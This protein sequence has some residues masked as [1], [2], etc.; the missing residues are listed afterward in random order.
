MKVVLLAGGLGSRLSEETDIRPKPLVQIGNRPILW[1]IMQMYARAGFDEFVVAAGYKGEL[2]ASYFDPGGPGMDM[3][4]GGWSVQVVDTGQATATAGRLRRLA[5]VLD[6]RPFMVTYGDGLADI[7]LNALVA[8]HGSHDVAA[9]ITAVRPP[10]RFGEVRF[11]DDARV[12]FSEKPQV[13]AGWINGGFMVMEPEVLALID[14]DRASLEYDILEPLA[15]QGRVAAY[16]HTSFW[17]CMDT[18]RDVRT[19][20]ELWDSGQAPWASG[21]TA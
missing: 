19:L 1:H 12:A 2:I 16:Q 9:T 17:Q 5:D 20:R 7:D 3:A 15:A 4:S 18:L 6:A 8:L 14:G 10:A 13:A 21:A 11:L